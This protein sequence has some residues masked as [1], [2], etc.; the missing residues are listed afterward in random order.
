MTIKK[1][2]ILGCILIVLVVI[3]SDWI[4]STKMSAL[5]D[6]SVINSSKW[7]PIIEL[8]YKLQIDVIQV[9]QWLTDI[10]AT[11][12]QDGLNDGFTE[13]SVAADSFRNN[14]LALKDLYPERAEKINQMLPL[15]E[16]YYAV[17][18]SMA[19]A[20]I[21]GGAPL[22]NQS[23]ADFDEGAEA[24]YSALKLFIESAN[25]EAHQSFSKQVEQS[26][27]AKILVFGVF[28]LILTLMAGMAY[29]VFKRILTPI[30]AIKQ[31]VENTVKVGDFTKHY[32]H[33]RNDEIG[34]MAASLNSFFDDLCRIIK[35]SNQVLSEASK[36]NFSQRIEILAIG[37]LQTL[38]VGIN[39]AIDDIQHST[40]EQNLQKESLLNQKAEIEQQQNAM[41]KAAGLLEEQTKTAQQRNA[42]LDA[43]NASITILD[44]QD[45]I[46]FANAAASSLFIEL[47]TPL[48]QIDSNLNPTDLAGYQPVNLLR[49]YHEL[50]SFNSVQEQSVFEISH[51][52][53]ELIVTAVPVYNEQGKR[54][55][56]VLQWLDN[57]AQVQVIREIETI[58]TAA[59]KG[60]LQQRIN[61]NNKNG[62]IKHL[63]ASLNALLDSVTQSLSAITSILMEMEQG[64]LDSRINA[65]LEGEYAVIKSSTNNTLDIWGNVLGGLNTL[66][67]NL[68]T[69]AGDITQST[70][71]L[72]SRAE[73]QAAS[74]EETAS[75]MSE[76][77]NMI[78]NYSKVSAEGMDVAKALQQKARTGGDVIA[79]TTGAM[80]EIHSSSKKISEIITVI[81]EIAFQT[82]LLALNAAVEAARAGE[83]G[84]GFAVVAGEVRNL[85]QRSSKAAKQISTL[86]KESV[87]KVEIGSSLAAESTATL[88][89]IR[90]SV[91]KMES[92]MQSINLAAVEQKNAVSE[93]N[94]VVK[95]LD[96]TTQNNVQLVEQT[97]NIANELLSQSDSLRQ[98]LA[99][100]K[101]Y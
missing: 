57:T 39:Q 90:G 4:T 16:N 89:D 46:I 81:D 7:L 62:F 17:G 78:Q 41:Q 72:S 65:A 68:K 77:T 69:S 49:G 95:D 60:Q 44:D 47:A 22:G 2:A 55:S 27:S 79:R 5:E 37:D 80:S 1:Q 85:A 31:F 88:E 54:M 93:I 26:F 87:E 45:K 15:F 28:A 67:D 11:R 86:I 94:T 23:M 38:K 19:D 34:V 64:Q 42:A 29:G 84:R 63:C 40:A 61:L 18:K 99:F 74:L 35:E 9:Q 3:G 43:C 52:A 92:M 100:F 83:Q 12:G 24:I 8:T 14:L 33:G 25:A 98:S 75:T 32:R 73:Q 76:I 10:S 56:T 71:K 70:G 20:Y 66:A 13:A 91:N 97:A 51:K 53:V 30:D 82:N 6:N 50:N 59:S 48:K 36:G 58:V 101:G 96:N 21:K